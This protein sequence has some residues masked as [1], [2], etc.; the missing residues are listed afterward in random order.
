MKTEKREPNSASKNNLKQSILEWNRKRSERVAKE[1]IIWSSLIEALK[2]GSVIEDERIRLYYDKRVKAMIERLPLEPKFNIRRWNEQVSIACSIGKEEVP[3]PIFVR[4]NQGVHIITPNNYFAYKSRKMAEFLRSCRTEDGSY[5]WKKYTIW[6]ALSEAEEEEKRAEQVEKETESTTEHHYEKEYD[7]IVKRFEEAIGWKDWEKLD[8]EEQEQSLEQK[9]AELIASVKE[10]PWYNELEVNEVAQVEEPKEERGLGMMNEAKKGKVVEEP[11]KQEMVEELAI[12][13]ANQENQAVI[14]KRR[15]TPYAITSLQ[16]NDIFVFGSNIQG[17]HSGSAGSAALKFGAICG[18]SIGLKGQTYALP[19]EDL[20]LLA[21][22]INEFTDF[23]QYH[24][25]FNFLVTEVG[26]G[27]S[28]HS[29][30]QVAP[31]FKEAAKL[32]NISLPPTFWDILKGGVGSRIKQLIEQGGYSI[33]SF[34]NET[35]I[36][37]RILTDVLF[38]KIEPTCSMMQKILMAIPECDARWLINGREMP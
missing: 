4:L 10:E 15:I 17:V 25:E 19:S 6:D 13:D 22:H 33:P 36:P 11:K 14:V 3:Y 2:R 21:L 38:G 26:C 29:P 32:E 8:D 27:T 23:A 31:L 16:P 5:Q 28:N 34:A 7:A 9:T 30:L 1:K 35:G 37:A 20:K 18:V 24:P 12:V